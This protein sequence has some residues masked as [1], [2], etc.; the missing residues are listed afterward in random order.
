MEH[1]EED[2][3]GEV[4]RPHLEAVL[5][6]ACTVRREDMGSARGKD[7]VRGSAF[8]AKRLKN[9]VDG[10]RAYRMSAHVLR[11]IPPPRA[12]FYSVRTIFI[13]ISTRSSLS[14]TRARTKTGNKNETPVRGR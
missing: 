14:L 1:K 10:A 6:D 11:N 12:T 2:I 5:Y 7:K 4:V 9:Y 8:E 13:M 3:L